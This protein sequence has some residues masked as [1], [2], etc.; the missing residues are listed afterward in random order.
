MIFTVLGIALIMSKCFFAEI[1]MQMVVNFIF[2][3]KGLFDNDVKGEHVLTR[4]IEILKQFEQIRLTFLKI[5]KKY[6]R[7]EPSMNF[8]LFL[9]IRVL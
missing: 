6:K 3:T 5:E 2:L 1:I 4:N 8:C 9:V 7:H